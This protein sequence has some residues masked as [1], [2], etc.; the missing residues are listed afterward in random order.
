MTSIGYS[1]CRRE[2]GDGSLT[3]VL[4]KWERVPRRMHAYFPLGRATRT[5][6]R[7]F[8]DFLSDEYRAAADRAP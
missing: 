5:A 2:L 7:A 8:I 4:S 3:Q 6:A 1:V